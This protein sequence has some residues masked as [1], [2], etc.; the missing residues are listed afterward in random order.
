MKSGML[1]AESV[2]DLLKDADPE[3]TANT[4]LEPVEYENKLK[5]SWVYDELKSIRNVRPS[6]HN[7]IG[8]F[9]TMAYTALF[10]VLLRGKEPWTLS[11]GGADY[12]KLKPATECQQIE[13]PKP[14]NKLTFDILTSGRINILVLIWLSYLIVNKSLTRSIID[15]YEPRA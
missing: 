11:H 7:P 2:F 13:Y 10:S 4:G 9:G 15:Q 5:N 12:S 6:F 8:I 14:D 3:K 1:A